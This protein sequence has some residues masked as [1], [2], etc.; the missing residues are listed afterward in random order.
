MKL[1]KEKSLCFMRINMFFA[2]SR[3]ANMN[4]RNSSWR[5]TKFVFLLERMK[6]SSSLS[7]KLTN[8]ISIQ[9]TKVF[10]KWSFN[11][12]MA[13][14]LSLGSIQK[15]AAK[16][17]S[18]EFKCLLLLNLKDISFLI[19]ILNITVN[20]KNSSKDGNFMILLRNLK[21]WASNRCPTQKS[22]SLNFLQILKF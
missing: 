12:K 14:N 21:E 5:I 20:W 13:V 18:K 1:R 6:V 11:W 9:Q 4:K 19:S 2:N 8:L 10:I 22:Q 17:Y 16:K 7:V 3:M 15:S